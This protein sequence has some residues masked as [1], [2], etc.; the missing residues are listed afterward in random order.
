MAAITWAKIWFCVSRTNMRRRVA[1]TSRVVT[2]A[3]SWN[4]RPGRSVKAYSRPSGD[5]V[6]VSTI[7]GWGVMSASQLNSVS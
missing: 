7:C 3:P 4:I 2:G 6:Q 5:F 1:T